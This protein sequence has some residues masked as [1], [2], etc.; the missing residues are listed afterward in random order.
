MGTQP[1]FKL[2][3]W[4]S[5]IEKKLSTGLASCVQQVWRINR[6]PNDWLDK[7]F[8]ICVHLCV[9]RKSLVFAF[10]FKLQSLTSAAPWLKVWLTQSRCFLQY[11]SHQYWVVNTNLKS[12]I[13]VP[14]LWI[15]TAT[16]RRERKITEYI[17]KTL[18]FEPGAAGLQRVNATT[19]LLRQKYV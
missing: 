17:L 10:L 9:R 2:S 15:N 7:S 8:S 16:S 6:L 12:F 18:R 4:L 3:F 19:M 5:S 13:A 11:C 1:S 14:L